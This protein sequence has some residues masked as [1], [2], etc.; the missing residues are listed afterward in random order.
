MR[1]VLFPGEG[2]CFLREQALNN[3]LTFLFV[4]L[5]FAGTI[6]LFLF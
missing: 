6:L 2:P 5:L 4:S 3:R 1:T